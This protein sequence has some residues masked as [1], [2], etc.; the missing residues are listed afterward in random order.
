MAGVR[1][2]VTRV[3]AGVTCL[4]GA[5]LA[6]PGPAPAGARA[7]PLAVQSAPGVRA[8]EAAVLQRSGAV[9]EHPVQLLLLGDSIV[10]TLGMGLSVDAR[11]RYGVDVVDN[12]A[13]G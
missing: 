11:T 8:P 13:V 2:C 9:G 7:A 4:L 6:A 1:R 10:L 5:L 3:L 12:A